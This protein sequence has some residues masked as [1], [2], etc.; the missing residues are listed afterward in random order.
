VE[1][2]EK[3]FIFSN[4]WSGVGEG[5]EPVKRSTYSTFLS[6]GKKGNRVSG[7]SCLRRKQKGDQTPQRREE[8]IDIWEVEKIEGS[9]Y[10]RHS[11]LRNK[12]G[13][14]GSLL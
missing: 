8:K 12:T 13:K 9:E 2:G 11:Y 10:A 6:E 7:S 1:R 3:G 14:K 4:I 5:K